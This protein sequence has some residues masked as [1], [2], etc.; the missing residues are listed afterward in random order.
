LG[1]GKERV[2]PAAAEI[3][4][5]SRAVDTRHR[6]NRRL[7]VTPGPWVILGAGPLRNLEMRLAPGGGSIR[8][9]EDVRLPARPMPVGAGELDS[10]M[11]W[12]H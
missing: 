9:K 7:A 10:E 4:E 1:H 12:P 6:A 3:V 5:V 11:T 8:V 2:V